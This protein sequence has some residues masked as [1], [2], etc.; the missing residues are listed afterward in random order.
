[1]KAAARKERLASDQRMDA[2]AIKLA[3]AIP[4]DTTLNEVISI[5][6]GFISYAL[7]QMPAAT[8]GVRLE[9]LI[10]FIRKVGEVPDE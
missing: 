9:V 6:G 10:E 7:L 8:R 4:D 5:C 1:M 2:L 3:D